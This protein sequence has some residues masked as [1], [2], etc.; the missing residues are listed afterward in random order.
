[1]HIML[2]SRRCTT[3][4]LIPQPPPWALLRPD[5]ELQKLE[6]AQYRL[7]WACVIVEPCSPVAEVDPETLRLCIS[8]VLA[9]TLRRTTQ[10]RDPAD[11]F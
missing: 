9:L 10:W 7:A 3:L 5:P 8:C 4:C 1:M 6:L 11:A 2:E